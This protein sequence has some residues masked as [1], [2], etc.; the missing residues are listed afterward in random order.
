[1]S[2]PDVRAGMALLMAAFGLPRAQYRGLVKELRGIAKVYLGT[3]R[4]TVSV[5]QAQ[6][7]TSKAK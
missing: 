3:Q 2:S 7:S 5:S 4:R 6:R 1:M